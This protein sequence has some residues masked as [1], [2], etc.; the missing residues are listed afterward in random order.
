[1]ALA[2]AAHPVFAQFGVPWTRSPTIT[3]VANDDDPR[4]ELVV[5][6]VAFWN[7]TLEEIGS[8]FRLGAITRIDRPIPEQALQGVS[9]A[10]VNSGGRSPRVLPDLLAELPGDLVVF[11]AHT[12]F[13]SFAAPFDRTGRRYVAIRSAEGPPLNLP[14]V[15]PNLIAHELGH[16][17]GFGHNADPKFLM[18]GRPAPCRPG[19]FQSQEPRMFPLTNEERKE[20]LRMYPHDWLPAESRPD[21]RD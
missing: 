7:K 1:M 10:I 6:A 2:F 3:V 14:N 11:L 13:V 15:A 16:A 17:I 9:A 20:L 19:E 5:A 21:K 4:I 8:G 12:T 18:C